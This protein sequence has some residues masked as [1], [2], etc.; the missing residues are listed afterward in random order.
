MPPSSALSPSPLQGCD[1]G[2]GRLLAV[3]LTAQGYRV[4]ASCFTEDGPRALAE[5]THGAA[6][7]I[8][9]RLDVTK[10]DE[11]DACARMIAAHC[12]DGLK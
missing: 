9:F 8:T 2:F 3:R 10:Q 6:N 1:T 11:I 7:L 12:P 4:F 5:E